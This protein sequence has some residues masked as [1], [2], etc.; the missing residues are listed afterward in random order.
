MLGSL[1][2]KIETSRHRWSI[3]WIKFSKHS[4]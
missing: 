4:F 1:R 3:F 2:T